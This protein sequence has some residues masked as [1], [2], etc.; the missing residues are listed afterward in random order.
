MCR[1]FR[2]IARWRRAISAGSSPSWFPSS[3]NRTRLSPTVVTMPASLA[4]RKR[5]RARAGSSCMASLHEGD[6][7]APSPQRRSAGVEDGVVGE[8]D[9]FARLLLEQRFRLAEQIDN[10][11]RIHRVE[12]V[13]IGGDRLQLRRL[14]MLVH[15]SQRFPQP[16]LQLKHHW[17]SETG[18]WCA[19]F[20]PPEYRYFLLPSSPFPASSNPLAP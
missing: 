19:G 9:I 4:L 18:I 5:S 10:G 1:A 11:H 16:L 17:T 3:S 7:V 14:H 15:P 12:D 2:P 6:P 20:G 8:R 13:E